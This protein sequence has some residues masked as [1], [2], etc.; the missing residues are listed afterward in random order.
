V[1]GQWV[2]NEILFD[3]KPSGYDFVEF[4]NNGH[5]ILD[6]SKLFIANRNSVGAISS[7]RPLSLQPF[8]VFPGDYLVVAEDP[9]NLILQYFIKNIGQILPVNSLPSFPNEEGTV[10]ALDAQGQVID[11]LHYNSDWH[12]KLITNAEGISL[13][14]IDPDG[15]TQSRDNWHSASSTAGYATPAAQNSQ[16]KAIHP[17]DARIEISPNIFSPDND[18]RDDIASIQYELGSPGYVANVIIYDR[19]G[20]VVRKLV[21]QALVGIKGRWN[22]DGLDDKGNPLPIGQYV[23][24]TQLFNLEGKKDLFKNAVVLA[25]SIN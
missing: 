14:R 19:S 10:V 25:R 16:Y 12:F 4:F 17:I 1:P 23:V 24:L 20:Q 18:G 6:A 13:E 21:Q 2:I 22:W 5:S 3:P 7:A 8:Q 9:D 15:I 11:E